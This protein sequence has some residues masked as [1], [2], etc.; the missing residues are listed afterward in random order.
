MAE[1]F[2][3]RLLRQADEGRLL[4]Y[5]Q[6]KAVVREYAIQKGTK[7][8][9]SSL[10][11]E[12]IA[13]LTRQPPNYNGE[14]KQS[15][16][17]CCS[18]R[19]PTGRWCRGRF[20]FKLIEHG[21]QKGY[22]LE[23][24][25]TCHCV[26]LI[27]TDTP[28][29]T[30]TEDLMT[31][32]DLDRILE[33]RSRSQLTAGLYFKDYDADD[34]NGPLLASFCAYSRQGR[35]RNE[36]VPTRR[37]REE[38]LQVTVTR[39]QQKP[40]ISKVS[41]EL[42]P[43]PEWV[44]EERRCIDT[45]ICVIGAK[46]R[47][48]FSLA[49]NCPGHLVAS[50]KCLSAGLA[51]APHQ[52]RTVPEVF[53]DKRWAV[54]SSSLCHKLCPS[55]L[56]HEGVC[57]ICHLRKPLAI[58]NC[59]CVTALHCQ[60]CLQNW[61]NT[62]HFQ[63]QK[64]PFPDFDPQEYDSGSATELPLANKTCPVCE[65]RQWMYINPNTN[66]VE[67]FSFPA[68]FSGTAIR[69]LSQ[70][71]ELHEDI[72]TWNFDCRVRDSRDDY[73]KSLPL[74]TQADVFCIWYED[75][76]PSG[77]RDMPPSVRTRFDGLP[78]CPSKWAALATFGRRQHEIH[79]LHGEFISME[80]LSSKSQ[81]YIK[82]LPDEW[83]WDHQVSPTLYGYVWELIRAYPKSGIAREARRANDTALTSPRFIHP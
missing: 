57:R 53:A 11:K 7:A 10:S 39:K 38:A 59:A 18:S 37:Q 60:E 23:N 69:P 2:V 75:I 71:K 16:Q 78:P 44:A 46:R 4:S 9:D 17:L 80:K 76:S 62:R 65:A 34:E 67:N 41:P 15:F 72:L 64:Y 36:Q 68:G 24:T 30:G 51:V 22:H 73:N 3:H 32:F 1:S 82:G 13:D 54:V 58:T 40:L 27:A 63:P 83:K 45:Q 50:N 26:P 19:D 79:H 5:P 25:F 20:M 55:R 66:T 6:C 31:V 52:T 43:E 48:D 21:E 56:V 42:P 77:T 14:S 61:I 81:E 49:V 74:E 70:K 29:H 12:D 28:V 33:D 35:L 47:F 8:F